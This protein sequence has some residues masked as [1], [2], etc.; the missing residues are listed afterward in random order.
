MSSGYP[1]SESPKGKNLHLQKFLLC[2]HWKGTTGLSSSSVCH[3][4]L[5]TFLSPRKNT[6][7]TLP[8]CSPA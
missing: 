3:Y 4:A 8:T 5:E 1:N 2:L 6:M 7:I